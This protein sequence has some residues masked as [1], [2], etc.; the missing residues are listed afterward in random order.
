MGNWIRDYKQENQ[1]T[2]RKRGHRRSV[3]A[4]EERGQRVTL[5]KD[6]VALT[7]SEIKAHFHK[8]CSLAALL[9]HAGASLPRR[10]ALPARRGTAPTGMSN[11]GF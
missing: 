11:C 7:L 2:P 9:L 4:Q 8:E 1:L 10:R 6:K 5:L 3:F